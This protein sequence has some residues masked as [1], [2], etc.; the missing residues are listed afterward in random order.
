M[1]LGDVESRRAGYVEEK[2]WFWFWLAI[3]A[4]FPQFFPPPPA[5]IFRLYV[6]V[7][8]MADF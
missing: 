1:D 7:W 4:F 2:H 6:T 5:P 8:D 3:D